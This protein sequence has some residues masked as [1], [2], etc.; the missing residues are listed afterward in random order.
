MNDAYLRGHS[1]M[2]SRKKQDFYTTLLHFVTKYS[3]KFFPF[4][5]TGTYVIYER[6]L[7]P[8]FRTS[9]W[10]KIQKNSLKSSQL[11]EI[12]AQHKNKQQLYNLKFQKVAKPLL[13][14]HKYHEKKN[15][16]KYSQGNNQ[17]IL[18]N[19]P[20]SLSFNACI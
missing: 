14:M 9:I 7:I 17:R 18:P 4:Y 3:Y 6:S 11:S 12:T 2:T 16:V 15:R 10:Y 5:G 8:R 19:P 20:P 1:K 13:R